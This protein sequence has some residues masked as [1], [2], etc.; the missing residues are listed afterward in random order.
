MKLRDGGV[1]QR[2]ARQMMGKSGQNSPWNLGKNPMHLRFKTST[3][4]CQIWENSILNLE[5]WG[6]LFIHIYIYMYNSMTV[7]IVISC[8]QNNGI[9][10]NLVVFHGRHL[11]M[12]HVCFHQS[13]QDAPDPLHLRSLLVFTRHP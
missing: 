8:Q 12:D 3:G 5:F 9:L 4:V 10:V 2:L 7:Y 6:V 13:V 1:F 11:S